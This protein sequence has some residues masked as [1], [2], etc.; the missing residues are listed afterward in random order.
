MPH[1]HKLID[2][3]IDVFIIHQNKVLLIFHKKLKKWLPIGGHIELNEDPDEAL[4]REVEEECGLK[5]EVVGNKPNIK[6]EG[7][8]FLYPP[9]FLDIHNITDIH[10]HVGL[11]YFAR[12]KS[13]KF[14]LNKKEHDDIRWFN[15]EDLDNPRFNLSPAVKFYARKALDD[16]GN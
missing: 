15:K 3:V 4:F 10:K 14:V 12:A 6:S 2:F 16:Y 1:I 5:I 9:V 7:T 8:K 13:D 11:Y